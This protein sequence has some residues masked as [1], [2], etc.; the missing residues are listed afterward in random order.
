M[1]SWFFEQ[2][3]EFVFNS[4]SKLTISSDVPIAFGI[5]SALD[6]EQA[7]ERALRSQRNKGLEVA[8]AGLGMLKLYDKYKK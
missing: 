5:I 4:I 1:C 2:I 7:E 3:S 8:T 6:Y